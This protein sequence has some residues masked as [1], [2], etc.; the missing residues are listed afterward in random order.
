M[1]VPKI[2]KK[3]FFYSSFPNKATPVTRPKLKQKAKTAKA[4]P[5]MKT[6]SKDLN[7]HRVIISERSPRC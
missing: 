1:A 5:R 7:I 3:R 2:K 6:D 4:K